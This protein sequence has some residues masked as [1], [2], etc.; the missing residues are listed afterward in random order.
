MFCK[1]QNIA[2]EYQ[3]CNANENRSQTQQLVVKLY[4]IITRYINGQIFKFLILNLTMFK[5]DSNF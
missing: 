2:L 3:S 4:I 5:L 1:I